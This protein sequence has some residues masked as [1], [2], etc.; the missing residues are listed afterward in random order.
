MKD[1]TG[2]NKILT[3][4]AKSELLKKATNESSEGITISSMSSEDRPLIYVNEGFQRM[5]GYLDEE[6][7][8]KNC[9]FLQG[10][11]TDQE[12]VQQIRDAVN[13]GESCIVELLNY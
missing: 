6:V 4:I 10:K 2:I 3:T 11:N 5:T 13:K 7:I 12:A 1:Q 8:G 9:R